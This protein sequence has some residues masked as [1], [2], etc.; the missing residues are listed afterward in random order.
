VQ[1]D[2][3]VQGMAQQAL[4][5]IEQGRT[6]LIAGCLNS[7][8]KHAAMVPV[9]APVSNTANVFRTKI[10]ILPFKQA[11]LNYAPFLFRLMRKRLC[12]K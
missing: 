8:H 1:V 12:H 3:A 10:R 11:L 7:Q 2:L 6:G 9:A 5:G 4:S